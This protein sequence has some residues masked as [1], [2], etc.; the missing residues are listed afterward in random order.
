MLIEWCYIH[1][2]KVLPLYFKHSNF[3]SFARQLNFYGF[4][5]LRPDAILT[6]DLDPSTANHVRF[7]H[8]YFHRDKPE[9]LQNIKRATTKGQ[10]VD[11]HHSKNEVEVLR[12]EVTNLRNELVTKTKECNQK[13]AEL[14]Y[15]CNRRISALT[16]DYEK[17]SSM[18]QTLTQHAPSTT[19]Q[20]QFF[21]TTG[22]P[23]QI[24]V[25]PTLAQGQNH[26]VQMH[27]A[28]AG[29]LF[30]SL[31]QAATVTLQQEGGAGGKRPAEAEANSGNAKVAKSSL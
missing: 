31:S 3:S 4:R 25:L 11:Q 27:L 21:A 26:P 7:Y 18:V 23:G 2:Q 28:N 17:L 12:Q 13:I 14:S 8:Q 24:V 6:T 10:V 16:N 20:Q 5:K 29:N 22:T 30:Q 19:Q 1:T 15:D 9:L